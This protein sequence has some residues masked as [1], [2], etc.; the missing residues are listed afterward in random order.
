MIELYKYVQFTICYYTSLNLFLKSVIYHIEIKNLLDHLN[1]NEKA[2]DKSQL[3]FMIF[4]IT[5]S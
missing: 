2:F 5:L 4:K 1:R 3:I